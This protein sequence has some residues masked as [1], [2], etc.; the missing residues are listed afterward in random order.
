ML[1]LFRNRVIFLKCDKNFI[2]VGYLCIKKKMIVG[3]F[4]VVFIN[5]MLFN[6]EKF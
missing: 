2:M 3:N 1:F 5:V 4:G 6:Y